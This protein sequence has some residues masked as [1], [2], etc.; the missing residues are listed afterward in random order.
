MVTSKK[1][2]QDLIKEAESTDE[3]LS[4]E[5]RFINSIEEA[6]VILEKTGKLCSVMKSPKAY[7]RLNKDIKAVTDNIRKIQKDLVSDKYAK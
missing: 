5:E 4:N 3:A 2:I 1:E 7:V 6:R